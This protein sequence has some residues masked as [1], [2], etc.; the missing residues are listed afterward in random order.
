LWIFV[1]KN[2]LSFDMGQWY[3]YQWLEGATVGMG[4]YNKNKK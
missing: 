2:S 4:L 3:I 1:F